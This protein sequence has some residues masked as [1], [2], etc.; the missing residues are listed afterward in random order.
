VRRCRA[1]RSASMPRRWSDETTWVT[2][3]R[4]GRRRALRLLQGKS[5]RAH[6]ADAVNQRNAAQGHVVGK[7]A[8]HKREMF[9]GLVARAGAVLE[10]ERRS[11]ALRYPEFPAA[12]QVAFDQRARAHSR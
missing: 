10:R 5:A 11:R 6:L 1:T 7:V 12:G 4:S 2:A 3:G 8:A 9:P